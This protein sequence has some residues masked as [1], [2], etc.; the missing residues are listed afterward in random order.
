MKEPQKEKKIEC[1]LKQVLHHTVVQQR[2]L[3]EII[4][5]QNANQESY[6]NLF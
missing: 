1:A 3:V 4:Q 2:N 5:A 6:V